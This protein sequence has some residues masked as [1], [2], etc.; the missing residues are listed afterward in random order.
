VTAVT[1]SGDVVH[2]GGK[3]MKNVAGLDLCKM[4][5]G[6][7]GTLGVITEAVLRVY[8]LPEVARGFYLTF[9][10]PED[11]FRMI[12]R[13]LDS[14]LTPSAIELV[15]AAAGHYMDGPGAKLQ[16]GEVLLIITAEGTSGDVERHDRD[17]KELAGKHNVKETA[18]LE[19]E[20]VV[21]AWKGYHHMHAALL[22]SDPAMIQGKAS[23]PISRL[24]ELFREVKRAGKGY[25]LEI[26][27]SAHGGN[28]IL[29]PYF[30]AGSEVA[31]RIIN[32]IKSTAASLGGFFM[33]EAAPLGIRKS[34]DIMP[35]RNDYQLMKRLKAEFDPRNILNPGRALGGL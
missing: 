22:A 24:G 5:V 34:V 32:D 26:A 12:G 3:T 30:T 6:S 14:P 31:S 1:P 15:D 4:Y 13:V 35:P 2:T 23:V 17:I 18:V 11:A 8:P 33:V 27:I 7:W 10:G 16:D 28:G 29:Y 19:G 9:A 21:K 20:E 25:G